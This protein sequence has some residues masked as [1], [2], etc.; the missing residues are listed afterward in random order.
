M[1]QN[2]ITARGKKTIAV[3]LC[4]A[5]F[6]TLFA[7]LFSALAVPIKA[8]A[9]NDPVPEL[10]TFDDLSGKTIA[11]LT[12]A[13]FEELI[14]EKNPDVGDIQYFS[15]VADMQLALKTGK[16][17]AF[18]NNNAIA[19][20]MMNQDSS[21]A[22]F[23]ESLGETAFGYA[24]KK[25][26]PARDKWQAAYD[27]IG[28]ERIDELWDIW[29]G[30]DES[31]K[32]LPA[33]DWSGAN[34][35]VKVA[36]CDSAPPMSYVGDNGEPIGFD[37]AVMLEIAKELD[38]HLEF[39]GMEF[40]SIMS[41]VE[42]GKATVGTASIVI[43]DERKKLVDFVP[44]HSASFVLMVRA[45]E[46]ASSH[47]VT[48]VK[49][50]EYTSV[51]ELNGR[52]FGLITGSPFEEIIESKVSDIDEYLY[53]SSIPDMA[54]ALKA[55]KID[56]FLTGDIIANTMINDDDGLAAFPESF[57]ELE[58]VFALPKDSPDTEKWQAA[59][60]KLGEEHIQELYEIWTGTDDSKKVLPEQNWAGANGTVRVASAD[61]VPPLSYVADDGR[62]EGMEIAILLEMAE[63]LD[64]HLDFTGM[65]LTAIMSSLQT[66]K[67]DIANSGLAATE[68]RRQTLDLVPYR[69]GSYVLVIRSKEKT[70][71]VSDNNVPE[72]QPTF[73]DNLKASFERT[74]ITD[75]R[76]KM[77]LLGLGRT[78]IMA[79]CSGLLGTLLG[80]GLV[81][82]RHRNNVVINKLIE[83]YSSL[84]TGIPVVV[85]LMVMYYIVFGKLDAPAL[86]VAIIGFTIIFGARAYGLIYNAVTAVDEGQR[87]AALAL[88]YSE[89]LAFRRVILPQSRS[90]YFPTLKMQFVMLLKE[91]SIAGYITVLEMTRAVDLVRSRTMEAFFPLITAAAI[92]Y[93]LT[94]LMT[95]I[96]T[97]TETA[98]NKKREQR[99][100]KGVD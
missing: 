58:C 96:I 54:L 86:I 77:I 36:A 17:D 4:A 66:G 63:E 84:I 60:D 76:W 7:Q 18:L 15:S 79:I 52:K 71:T 65:E 10:K 48:T 75:S 78:V 44:Y 12:G 20:M 67:A 35:T 33:Q 14:R 72:V 68:E 69:K 23:P 47:R 80:F 31:R 19:T 27:R 87:E 59:C 74:F 91:T 56:A 81:L 37:I 73:T 51:S 61:S 62:L 5:V 97:L 98:L 43:S 25:G 8:S 9:D 41:E 38:V 99:K 34:G 94:W 22:V 11:M 46:G 70:V 13:P 1:L 93:I 53:F 90:I 83:I 16:V 40:A 26:D 57:G 64:V 45:E 28:S 55:G 39:T 88:G 92:Y 30:T 49:E 50:P 29:L 85:I 42:S 2:T 32:V 82:L 24:F 95:N 6:I 89:K 100:I 21:L 3:M